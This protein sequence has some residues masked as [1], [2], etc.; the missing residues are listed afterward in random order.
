MAPTDAWTAIDENFASHAGPMLDSEAYVML[1]RTLASSGIAG[2]RTYDAI[3]AACARTAGAQELLTL[4]R[5]DFD[6]VS[7]G[8]T[9]VDPT[10]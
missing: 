3:I 9:V 4:N 1:L 2:G 5:R 7:G 10:A 6:H 8:I